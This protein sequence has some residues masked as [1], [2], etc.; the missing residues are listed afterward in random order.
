MCVEEVLM[1]GGVLNLGGGEEMTVGRCEVIEEVLIDLGMMKNVNR[2]GRRE[3]VMGSYSFYHA[4][5]TFTELEEKTCGNSLYA[6]NE[7]SNP[8]TKE[9]TGL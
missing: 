6:S 7:R 3:L 8:Q 4:Q 9:S 1:A 2:C 5:S